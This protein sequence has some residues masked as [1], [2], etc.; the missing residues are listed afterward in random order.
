M[1]H[2]IYPTWSIEL[3]EHW[4]REEQDACV[5]FYEPASGVG[6]LQLSSATK[7]AGEVTDAD[8]IDKAERNGDQVTSETS[9]GDFL[10]WEY[11]VVESES[12][13]RKWCLRAGK[14]LLFATYNCALEDRGQEDS[15]IDAAMNSLRLENAA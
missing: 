11:S 14:T 8:L 3:P 15:V 4:S 12:Y 2:Q 7:Q 10:G 6:A 13:W 5:A 1:R 9:Y